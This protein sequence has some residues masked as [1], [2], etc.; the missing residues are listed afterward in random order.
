MYTSQRG[1]PRDYG[2]KP[3]EEQGESEEENLRRGEVASTISL[4]GV[5]FVIRESR[6]AALQGQPGG[7]LVSCAKGGSSL[8]VDL[9]SARN[10]NS[11]EATSLIVSIS[12]SVITIYQSSN[13][14]VFLQDKGKL[15]T[16]MSTGLL[17]TGELQ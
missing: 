8:E 7:L 12:I 3:E 14:E 2:L 5:S 17:T 6:S 4:Q 16:G 15:T 13:G 10:P 9:G 1:F 11:L